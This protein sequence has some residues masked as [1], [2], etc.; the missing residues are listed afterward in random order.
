MSSD[1]VAQSPHPIALPGQPLHAT[2]G[3]RESGDIRFGW[4]VVLAFFGVFL[5][6]AA[7]VRLDAAAYAE[8]TVKV[9]GSRQAVQHRD[10]GTVAALKVR[11]GQHV[12]AG[13]VLIELAGAE[14]AANERAMAAQVIGL[15]AERARLMA[16]R[17]GAA[18]VAAPAS[19][20]QLTGENRELANANMRL[21]QNALATKRGAIGAQ[22]RVL[23][24]QAAQLRQRIGGIGQQVT[25]NRKQSSLFDDSWRVCRCWS[26]RAMPASIAFVS[27][28]AR[29][30]AYRV[31][32][33]ICRR[34]AP[35]RASRSARRRCRR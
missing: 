7:F 24:Q 33:P 34:P 16:E 32:W 28:S 12:E 15:Q 8:G 9:S 20:A 21:Q 14:V 13:Q 27:W 30:P 19:F 3:V 6:F 25:Q 17:T 2:E 31:I 10:G 11:E 35:R 29:A 5:G 22:K 4:I 18:G 26:T 23:A 1:L